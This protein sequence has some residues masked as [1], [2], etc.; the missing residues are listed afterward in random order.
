[1][2]SSRFRRFKPSNAI[3]CGFLVV[4]FVLVVCCVWLLLICFHCFQPPEAFFV[5][6]SP[7]CVKKRFLI[8]VVCCVYFVP[9]FFLLGFCFLICRISAL[10]LLLQGPT[11]TSC[12]HCPS[13]RLGTNVACRNISISPQR[14]FSAVCCMLPAA[15]R[16]LAANHRRGALCAK[17]SQVVR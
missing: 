14:T 2:S 4:M 5:W 7:C 15:M 17:N 1:M 13:K 10:R 16:L 11:P 12:S 8:F 3:S 6:L 9:L